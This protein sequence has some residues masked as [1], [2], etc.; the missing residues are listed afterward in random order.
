MPLTAECDK[1]PDGNCVC[2]AN[3]QH[4]LPRKQANAGPH[5]RPWHTMHR[6][7]CHELQTLLGIRT[8]AMGTV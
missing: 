6:T 5:A 1:E 7:P 2:F 8:R 4:A 3:E